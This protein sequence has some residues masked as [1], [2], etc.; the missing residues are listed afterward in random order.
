VKKLL[1]LLLVLFIASCQPKLEEVVSDS[2][3]NGK[4]KRVQYFRGEGDQ[5]HLARDVF[6]Y[7]DGTKKVEGWYNQE[8]RKDGAWT[9]WYP[10]GKKWSEGY[11]SNGIDDRLRTTWHENGQMHYRG[12]YDKGTRVG[13]WKFYDEN[14]KLAKEIDYDKEKE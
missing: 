7:E 13:V 11:F 12:K 9:F 14:G 3:P 2:Y 1:Y 10:N 5:R 4:P 8:G 6:Y